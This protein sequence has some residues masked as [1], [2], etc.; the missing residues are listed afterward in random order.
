MA[1]CPADGRIG[2]LTP[3]GKQPSLPDLTSLTTIHIHIRI[4]YAHT[5]PTPLH[6]QSCAYYSLS[7]GVNHHTHLKERNSE[8]ADQVRQYSSSLLESRRNCL[9]KH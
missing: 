3:H 4:T 9:D 2:C 6:P 7:F 8:H 5:Q 1:E